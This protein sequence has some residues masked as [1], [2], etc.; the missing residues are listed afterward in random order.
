M[1]F[2]T[3]SCMSKKYFE[4]LKPFSYRNTL[5]KSPRGSPVR[6][7]FDSLGGG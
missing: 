4:S 1:N 3:V 7:G 5:T 2:S 6:M